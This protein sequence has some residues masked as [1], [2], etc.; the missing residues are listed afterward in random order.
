MGV[1]FFDPHD[2]DYKPVTTVL[3]KEKKRAPLNLLIEKS[4]YP[5]K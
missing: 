4:E 3:L 5:D 2:I 1:F